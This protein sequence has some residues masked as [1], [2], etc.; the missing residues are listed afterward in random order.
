MKILVTGAYSTGKS[1][2][3][4]ELAGTL[5]KNGYSVAVLPDSSRE[6]TL[7]LN[8]YQGHD[9]TMWLLAWQISKEKISSSMLKANSII[10]CDRGV[11]DILSHNLE[12]ITRN[13]G[14]E[15]AHA[16]STA[17]DWCKSYDLSF[18][19]LIDKAI[20]INNDGLRVIDPSFRQKMEDFALET[21]KGL[22]HCLELPFP[23]ADRVVFAINEIKRYQSSRGFS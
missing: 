20:P 1:I 5:R 23:S 18:F 13:S 19:S 11:P 10:L 17:Q 8:R 2:F 12:S 22:R 14:L 6:I 21:T 16:M 9:T 3:V 15:N 7:P 4:N